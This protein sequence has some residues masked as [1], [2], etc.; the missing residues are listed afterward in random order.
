MFNRLYLQNVRLLSKLEESVNEQLGAVFSLNTEHTYDIW[1][2]RYSIM[3]LDDQVEV[4][5]W[6]TKHPPHPQSTEVCSA[7]H[8]QLHHESA[9]V[10]LLSNI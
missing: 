8:N 4:F 2:T 3:K 10:S 6:W 5:Y 9:I 7:M 1:Q